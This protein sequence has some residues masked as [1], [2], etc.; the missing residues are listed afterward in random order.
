MHGSDGSEVSGW[1]VSTGNSVESSPTVA[2]TG[3]GSY[4]N[5]FVSSGSSA[6]TNGSLSSYTANGVQRWSLGE[7]SPEAIGQPWNY[8]VPIQATPVVGPF[9]N[10]GGSDVFAGTLGIQSFAYNQ[11]GQPLWPTAIRG[12][13]PYSP[14]YQNDTIFSSPA[15]ADLNGSGTPQIIEGGDSSGTPPAPATG[16]FGGCN[17]QGGCVRSI[18]GLTGAVNWQF[19]TNDT[20]DS[21]PAIGDVLGNGQNQVVFGVG[22]YWSAY[23]AQHGI[24]GP[25]DT[26]KIFVL[27][28]DGSLHCEKDLGGITVGSPALAD[29]NGDGKLDIVIGTAGQISS[30]NDGTS[31]IWVLDGNCNPLPNWP[32]ASPGGVVIGGIVTANLTGSATGSQD[33]LVP[34]GGG[35]YAFN[36]RT[37]ALMFA[38]D[39][40]SI[41]YENSPLVV[42]E[43]GGN[44]AIYLAGTLAADNTGVVSKYV[45]NTGGSIG[46]SAWPMF[47]LDPRHTG[48]WASSPVSSALGISAAPGGSGYWTA[49]SDGAVFQFGSAGQFG[50]AA[51]IALAKPIVGMASTPDGK[52][53]WLVASDGGIFAYGDAQFYGSIGSAFG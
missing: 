24:A 39:V 19:D 36:G 2:Y 22:Y 16:L 14:F 27:N 4:P 44:L 11:A 9:G 46:A 50:S 15:L 5:V 18:N 49:S 32:Q 43:G 47:H 8:S 41:S 23:D 21:S 51:N 31:Q 48:S 34:T 26:T 33:L 29:I 40:G 6:T 38:T 53:Y 13:N 17:G 25:T 42:D 12:G 7:P 35:M 20:V 52:G 37:G 28:S 45:L 1:P 3:G 30:A 10:D